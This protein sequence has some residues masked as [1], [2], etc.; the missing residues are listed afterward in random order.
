MTAL[1]TARPDAGFFSRFGWCLNP[2]LSVE[3]L[4]RRALE[5]WHLLQ[6][7]TEEWQR[8]ECRVNLYLLLCAL[9]CTIGDYL[10]YR[11]W[12][13]DGL[14]R[15][16]SLPGGLIAAVRLAVNAP[17]AW[18]SRADRRLVRRWKPSL[19][20]SVAIAC[21]AIVDETCGEAPDW[22]ALGAELTVLVDTRLP[23]GAAGWRA[24]IPEAFRCQDLTHHDVIEMARRLVDT[25]GSDRPRELFV[26]G[27]RT[28][29]AYFAP[30]VHACLERWGWRT[31]GWLTVRLKEGLSRAER[32]RLGEACAHG[33]H[34]VIVDD[35]P[36]TGDT[37]VDLVA[38][39]RR[40]KARH[41][42]I[43]APDHPAQ[44]DWAVRVSPV[45][46]VT[47]APS[48]FHKARLL[49]DDTRMLQ[50]IREISGA[51]TG[52]DL[53]LERTATLDSLNAGLRARYP[54]SF[55]VRLKRVFRIERRT[56]GEDRRDGAVPAEPSETT[57]VLAKSVGWGWLGYHAYLAADRLTDFVPRLIGVRD[58]LMFVE[59]LGGEDA[60][61]AQPAPE[62]IAAAVPSYVAARVRGLQLGE[63]P[64]SGV[65][66]YRRTGRDRILEVL[67]RPYGRVLGRLAIPAL[68]RA[69]AKLAPPTPIMV[70]GRMARDNWLMARGRVRKVDFEHHNFG[71]GEQDIVDPAYDLAGAVHELK[72]DR[73]AEGR[74][75][76]AYVAGTG[77][78][79]V[80][81]RLLLYKL[82]VGLLA[83]DKAAAALR[84][85]LSAQRQ[86]DENLRFL[87][88]RDF[89][90]YQLNR[91]H[92]ARLEATGKRAWTERLF[93]LD[94]DGV[95]DSQAF[96]FFPHT[97]ASGLR[98]LQR[99]QSRGYAVIPNTGR[100]VEHVLDY[101]D[102]YGFPGGA[103]EYG[104]LFVDRIGGRVE[105]LYGPE[106]AEALARCRELAAGMPGV[107]VDSGYRAAVRLY[108]YR[109]GRW[110]GLASREVDELLELGRFDSLRAIRG[111]RDTCFVPKEVDKGTA[112][113][114]I[115]ARLPVRSA[116]VAAMGD[117]DAD[118]AMLR[119]ADFPYV[120]ANGSDALRKFT[121]SM[122]N[123]RLTRM[124]RQRGLFEAVEDLLGTRDRSTAAADPPGD[125][126]R[127]SAHVVDIA[128]EAL[129]RPFLSRWMHELATFRA[130][131][132]DRSPRVLR[133]A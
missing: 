62:S 72:L 33:A 37:F 71:G 26:L 55:Q 1:P 4:R 16:F 63:D 40:L 83:M 3:D 50:T 64:T 108:R 44:T 111:P 46:V 56:R 105:P 100:S 123:A 113:E 80:R 91:H 35:H 41:I 93:F 28:A 101:C 82:Y 14:A 30:L 42:V 116:L 67:R 95:F 120:P 73:V 7:S 126:V 58:G 23:A 22:S 9:D 18:I 32:R 109:D 115:K 51:G 5:S 15:R 70:D 20:R 89:L 88:S 60:P 131:A 103:A 31:S 87:W 61:A 104:C 43:L 12:K 8:R 106:A 129:D 92:A 6:S 53:R 68:D 98:A 86:R 94:L 130:A 112:V 24:R 52:T 121:R 114:S 85:P 36:N 45:R 90:T 79:A 48:E 74:L 110:A 39:A 66:G 97:T 127:P 84:R 133:A 34:V 21:R 102:C 124:A 69:L 99:L 49:E 96:G 119:R 132:S 47:L 29:G 77:D 59:W 81:D 54:D 57:L 27:P 38:L 13:L 19:D 2:V 17:D 118:L 25:F 75:V 107:H 76:D 78:D 11:R 65:V 125:P 122:P 128:L 117:S 10:S